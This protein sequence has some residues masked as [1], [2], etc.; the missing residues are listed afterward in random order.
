MLGSSRGFGDATQ[1]V[2]VICRSSGALDGAVGRAALGSEA[3]AAPIF[4]RTEVS[5][6]NFMSG[7]GV[8]RKCNSEVCRIVS[9]GGFDRSAVGELDPVEPAELTGDDDEGVGGAFLERS[10]LSE[11]FFFAGVASF[12]GGVGA[13]ILSSCVTIATAI[14]RNYISVRDLVS[15]LWFS[16]D[17]GRASIGASSFVSALGNVPFNPFLNVSSG[18]SVG[19]LSSRRSPLTPPSPSPPRSSLRFVLAL[20]GLTLG[21]SSSSSR[22]L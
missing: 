9:G 21:H 17:S 5:F 10:G 8:K 4:S 11:H 20:H 13:S 18:T 15:R 16:F 3:D 2:K 19:P 12:A 1:S 22:M 6:V 7:C 14:L